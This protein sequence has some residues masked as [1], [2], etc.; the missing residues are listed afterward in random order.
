MRPQT[1]TFGDLPS[2]DHFPLYGK[3]KPPVSRV[4]VHWQE[5]CAFSWWRHAGSNL[6]GAINKKQVF[7]PADGQ[8]LTVRP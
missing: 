6:F 2:P 3:M 1:K 5:F 7:I 8:T 4:M